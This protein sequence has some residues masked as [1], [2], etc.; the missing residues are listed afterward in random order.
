M[1]IQTL[2]QYSLVALATSLI[3]VGYI[4]TVGIAGYAR[5]KY[6]IIPPS[7]TGHP[8]FEKALRVQLNNLENMIGFLPIL[9]IFAFFNS[10]FW[11]GVLGL[12]WLLGRIIYSIGYYRDV[13][14]RVFGSIFY[15]PA[16]LIVLFGGLF[17]IISILLR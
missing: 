10:S 16:L 2:Q 11:A 6:K 7:T 14:S 9:W 8:D 3:V 5:T 17:S 12:M 4:I 15:A 13:K 1:P